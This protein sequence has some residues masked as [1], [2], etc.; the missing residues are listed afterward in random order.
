MYSLSFAADNPAAFGQA[1]PRVQW[2][3]NSRR[4]VDTQRQR[5]REM[6]SQFKTLGENRWGLAPCVFRNN[7]L[8][9]E[10]RPNIVDRDSLQ[11]GVTAPYAAGA[12][13]MFAP[14]ESVAALREFRSLRDSKSELVAWRDPAHGGYGF[15][16]SFSL[17]PP[18]GQN[19]TLG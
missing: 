3:E 9:H 16:D 19:E 13:I 1:G 6:A 5:C 4:A 7:Y 8:V 15:V 2:F 11:G 18:C 17:D 12:A 14:R 10:V